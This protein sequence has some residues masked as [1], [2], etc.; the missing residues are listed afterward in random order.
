MPWDTKK[1]IPTVVKESKGE[2]ATK[3][4]PI[5]EDRCISCHSPKSAK[6]KKN[7][8]GGLRL[9]A[10][11]WIM[12]GVVEEGEP[13]SITQITRGSTRQPNRIFDVFS[14]A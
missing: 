5:L 2:F 10:A 1:T 3:I 8:K 12:R 4:W 9:D 7:P 14:S 13:I 6:K 11:E